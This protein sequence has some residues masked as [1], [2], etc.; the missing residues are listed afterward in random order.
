MAY[1]TSSVEIQLGGVGSLSNGRGHMRRYCRF[2]T[3]RKTKKE[4]EYRD[5][6]RTFIRDGT[7]VLLTHAVSRTS[8]IGETT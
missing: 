5:L 1:Q 6:E 2:W 4:D 8:W 3:I 7:D